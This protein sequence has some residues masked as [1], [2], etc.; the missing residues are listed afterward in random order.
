MQYSFKKVAMIGYCI[1]DMMKSSAI[2]LGWN[3]DFSFIK[4]PVFRANKKN[5]R[6]VNE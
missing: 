1:L 5:E 6:L 3:L 4:D 2:I